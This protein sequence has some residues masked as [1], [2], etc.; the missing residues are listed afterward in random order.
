M[1]SRLAALGLMICSLVAAAASGQNKF[2]QFVLQDDSTGSY[3]EFDLSGSYFYVD[4]DKDYK[5]E[6]VGTA[7]ISGCNV[8][9]EAID[10]I[11]LVQASVDM[12]EARG[13]AAILVRVPCPL[14]RECEPVRLI[15]SDSNLTDSATACKKPN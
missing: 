15:I 7:R 12:C 3:L 1:K 11:R 13:K 6:G 5:V 9:L 10:K 4:C 14:G 8:T 2:Q